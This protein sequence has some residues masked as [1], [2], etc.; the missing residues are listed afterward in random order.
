MIDMRLSFCFILSLA[1]CATAASAESDPAATRGEC[2]AALRPLMLQNPPPQDALLA[3]R[4][5]CAAEAE[6]GD[7]DAEYQLAMLHLGL[8]DWDVDKAVPMIQS[9]AQRGVPEAQ[10]WLAWQYEEG[11]LLPNDARLAVQWYRSAGENDHRLALDRLAT[12]YQRGEL[13]LP[14]D[15]QKATEMRA[16]AEACANKAS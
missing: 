10:Y 5:L 13:G 6:A 9:A 7:A 2:R 3:V 12:A 4:S 16:R 8:I 1:L 11:P 14:V 15:S